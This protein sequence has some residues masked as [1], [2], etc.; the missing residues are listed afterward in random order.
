MTDLS[1]AAALARARRALTLV[2][3][4]G[5][6]GKGIFLTTS[7]LYFT[8]AVHLPVVEVGIGLSV[9]GVVSALLG[10]LA[11]HLADRHGPR[12]LY[13]IS[14]AVGAIST[15]CFLVAD[16]FWQFL[17][18]AAL[19]TSAIAAVAIVRGP[20]I[21]HIARERPQELRARV[22]AVTNVGI[23]LG[24]VVAGWAAQV[25]T[26]DA[27]RWAAISNAVCL[28]VAAVLSVGLP[29]LVAITPR[30]DRARWLALR[31]P[32][33]VALSVLDGF[34]SIQYRVLTVAVPLWVV[35]YTS[36]PRWLISAAVI[37]NTL[38]II[39][40]Q[41][42]ASRNIDHPEAAGRAMRRSGATFFLAC[43]VL[44][45]AAGVPSWIAATLL[46]AGIIIHSMG[47]LWQAAGGFEASNV[48]APPD[49]LG[50]YLGVFGIGIALAESL[51]P[52]LLTFLCIDWGRPGWFVMG[53]IFLASG[54]AVPRVVRWAEETRHQYG[55]SVLETVERAT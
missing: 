20:I 44:A 39:F 30:T 43:V 9:A 25:D 15:M 32:P 13:T 24:A 2:T 46:V 26:Q 21:N 54:L 42:R 12:L 8:R 18:V 35:S 3:L 23:A 4:V 7:A 29:K 28:A 5:A 53:L 40:F 16:T 41:V 34:L 48:L 31:D 27:Y 10:F 14:L 49:A 19:T 22:R 36:A 45:A 33:Y 52:A 55:G 47:E 51:G 11:G 6:L 50:Q 38:I 17:V 1:D 37:V